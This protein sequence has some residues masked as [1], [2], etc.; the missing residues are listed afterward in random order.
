MLLGDFR[1]ETKQDHDPSQACTIGNKR[2]KH[3]RRGMAKRRAQVNRANQWTG[4]S[5]TAIV[6][7][8]E[9]RS[10][11]LMDDRRVRVYLTNQ[12]ERPGKPNH[13]S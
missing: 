4:N 6:Q 13:Y 9:G 10:D 2:C 12:M 11:N 7:A 8:A 1:S 3:S 5:A